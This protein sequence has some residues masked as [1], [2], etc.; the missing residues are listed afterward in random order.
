MS[1]FGGC[2]FSESVVIASNY[3]SY[4]LQHEVSKQGLPIS[5]IVTL[6]F[7]EFAAVHM[8]HKFEI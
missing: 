4:I 1:F 5:D 3:T 8:K 2:L 7:A 6:L